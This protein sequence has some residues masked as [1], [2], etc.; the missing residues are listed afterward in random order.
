MQKVDSQTYFSV[1]D[2]RQIPYPEATFDLVLLLGNSF[3]YF[4]NADQDIAVL[5]EVVRV[6]RP[7][8][9]LVIDLT[10]GEYMRKNYNERSW[11]WVDDTTFVCRE[12]QLSEDGTRLYSREIITLTEKGVV[13]DQFYQERLYSRNDISKLMNGVGLDTSESQETVFTANSKRNEDLGMMDHRIVVTGFKPERGVKNMTAS[14]MI[15]SDVKQLSPPITILLGDPSKPCVGKLNDSWNQEDIE[16]REKL[17]AAILAAGYKSEVINVVDCHDSLLSTLVE[18]KP[19]FVF[20]LCDEG[21]NNEALKELH[22]PALLEMLEI[23]YS[24]AG[25]NCLAFCYDKGLVNRSAEVLGI[26]TP[27]EITF[28]GSAS[29]LIQLKAITADAKYPAFVKPV[30][31]DNSLGIT[32][33]SIV[34]NFEELVTYVN[35]LKTLQVYDILIQEY[36]EGDEYG[37][38]MIGNSETGFKFLPVIQVNYSKI[39]DQKLP[40]ILGFESKWDPKSPYWN[41]ISF[42]RANLSPEREQALHNSCKILWERFGCRDYAR[43]DFRSD[44]SGQIKLLEVNPNPGWCWDGKF[45]YMGRLDGLEYNELLDLI[46]KASWKRL[47][48]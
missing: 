31:G 1:G 25:P 21:W 46:L 42:E 34:N 33:R 17:V 4:S 47:R 18:N 7:G 15:I 2:C 22:V 20:N 29:D 3:G 36:L 5:K 38:G 11:E 43:F 10:D 44:S 48:L 26:S 35:E 41:D 6:L 16:T 45:A 40:P 24:G 30:K 19:S 12:R 14:P 28:L 27:K 32:V 23:P 8:G 39:L 37:V 9:R 13:R